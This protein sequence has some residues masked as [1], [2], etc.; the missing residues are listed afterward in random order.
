MQLK[1]RLGVFI[2][3]IVTAS[4]MLAPKSAHAQVAEFDTA[5]TVYYE[6]PFRTN[7]FVYSPSTDLKVTPVDALTVNAGWEADIVSGASVAVKAGPAYQATHPAADVVTTASVHDFRNVAHG[8]FT[9]RKDT[10]AFDANYAYSTE[11]DYKSHTLSFGATTDLYEH[12]TQLAINYA[13]NFDFVCDRTQAAQD[14]PARYAALENSDGCFSSGQNPLRKTD[15]IAIDGLQGSWSQSWTPTIATQLIYTAQITNGF[16]GNPYRSVIIGEGIKSQEHEPENRAR[17]ALAGRVNFFLRPLKAALRIGGRVYW[18]T[19]DVKSGT[20][21]AEFEKYFGERFRAEAKGRFYHQSGALFWSDD[22]SGGNAP[23]GPKGQYWTGDRELSPFSS[24]LVGLGATYA[25]TPQKRILGL[26][27][28]FKVSLSLDALQFIY[29][30]Y[31][32]GGSEVSSSR[33]YIA[34]L[35]LAFIF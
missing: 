4:S 6:A 21:D 32:L 34:N 13:R 17:E 18:D 31:T 8:G 10:V 1:A 29:D 35:S 23:L 15:D 7:M 12:N 22:Y 20:A 9:L 5:H 28:G 24:I 25:V 26:L 30:D 3:A 14:P 11:H 33:A 16:Q 2:F 19:W 27:S